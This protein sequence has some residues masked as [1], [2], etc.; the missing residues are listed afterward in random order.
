MKV[1]TTVGRAAGALV[2][3]ALIGNV[4]PQMPASAGTDGTATARGSIAA[5]KALPESAKGTVRTTGKKLN[6]RAAPGT[7]YTSFKKLGNSTKVTILCQTEGSKVKGPFGT[8]TIWDML[9]YGGFVS[10]AYIKTGSDGY[11]TDKCDRSPQPKKANPR[12]ADQ[13]IS[14]QFSRLGSVKGEQWCLRF[15]AQSFGY[16][17]AGIPTAEEAGD[18]AE[19]RQGVPPRG[20]LV[21]YHNGGTTG[22]IVLS[23]GEGLVIGTSVPDR[24]GVGPYKYGKYE[25]RGW[26]T[27]DFPEGVR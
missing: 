19:L 5:A 13:A 7:Q 24:V 25:Y 12:S 4:T 11:V 26:S 27:P 8:S 14:W 9:S 3:G 10:D 1:T 18:Q 21:W 2:A 16:V 15:Q 17:R 6:V 23:L 22:H 20:A